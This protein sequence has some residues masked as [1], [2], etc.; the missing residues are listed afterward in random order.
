M[1]IEIG[2]VP[3]GVGVFVAVAG[4]DEHFVAVVGSDLK[5]LLR[6]VI[7]IAEAAF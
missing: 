7:E 6:F 3:V 4:G 5:R 2:A 1:V